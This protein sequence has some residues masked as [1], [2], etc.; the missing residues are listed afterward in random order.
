MLKTLLVIQKVHDNGRVEIFQAFSNSKPFQ[1][2]FETNRNA[3]G[4]DKLEYFPFTIRGINPEKRTPGPET[5]T[6]VDNNIIKFVDDYGIPEGSVIAILFPPNFVPDI[7]KFKDNPY[8]PAGLAGQV[9]S[10]PPGQIQIV[11][12][13]FEKRSAII[14]HIHEKLL[15]GVKCIAKKV[16]DEDFPEYEDSFADE[17]FDVSISRKLLDVDII[18]TED[19]KIIN[20]TLDKVDLTE[21][22]EA[23]NS[24]LDALKKGDKSKSQSLLAKFGGLLM[25]GTGVAS[26]LTTILDSYND[27]NSASKFIGKVIEYSTL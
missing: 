12:N 24:I 1:W 13:R 19:L 17:L 18:K 3:N 21:I 7:I 16:S 25:N 8:I 26:N 15:F 20:D 2:T 9:T 14:L 11:Y 10:R 23:L 5:K 27:G 4:A 22:H 6:K